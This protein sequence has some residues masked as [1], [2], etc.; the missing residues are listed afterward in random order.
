M[1]SWLTFN[2]GV[3][4]TYFSG[5]LTER[6]TS[7]RAGAAVQLPGLHWIVRGFYGRYYQPPPLS[8]IS[9]PLLD[10]AL[11]QG[12]GFL[13][14]HGERDEQKEA[15]LAIPVKGWALDFTHY[16]T[17]ARNF[18]DHDVLGNSNIFL[19]LTIEAARLRG[20][21]A[22]VQSPAL[23][24]R[25]RIHL[26]YARQWAQGEGAVTGGLTDFSPPPNGMYY[27]DHD[28][29]DTLSAGLETQLPWHAWASANVAYGS[30]FLNGDGPDHMSSHTTV[31]MSLGKSFGENLSLSVDALN[32]ADSRYLLDN[33]STFGGTHYNY[34]R[35]ISL[36]LRYRIHY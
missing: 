31:D 20:W 19:P 33:S 13:P 24:G 17:N 23:R 10:L 34:P 9:G 14:L 32:L 35:Q 26:A 16:H 5:V 7:P 25:M 30:G 8:T 22:T 3:R 29:R 15:G 1:T 27:L 4:F 6:A 11:N 21:E 12:F 18:F 28:Q 36:T 2:G